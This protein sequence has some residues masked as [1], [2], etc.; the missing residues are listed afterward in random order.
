[1]KVISI[2]RFWAFLHAVRCITEVQ[3]GTDPE[4]KSGDATAI[5]NASVIR[6]KNLLF[7]K[8]PKI[9]VLLVFC[10]LLF[11]SNTTFANKPQIIKKPAIIKLDTSKVNIRNFDAEKIKTYI[12]KK[13][14]IYTDAPPETQSLWDRFWRWVWRII[15]SLTSGVAGGVVKY[16]A[17]TLALILALYLVVKFVGL[18]LIIFAKKPLATEITFNETLENIH[19]INFDQEI[20]KALQQNNFRLAVRLLYLQTLKNLSLNNI[21]VWQLQKTNQV[22]VTE[23]NNPSQKQQFANLTQ[24]FE[25][26]W[27][28][29]FFIDKPIFTLI[30]NSFHQFNLQIK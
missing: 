18:D 26:V 2:K 6:T 17:L 10:F 4:E 1:M 24:Q 29:E 13:D 23:I 8:N 3:I 7:F 20:E 27:Y 30:N 19:E 25:Y 21:I 12:K 28:G 22:Y 5:V 16:V 15:N 14:F 9:A 11:S